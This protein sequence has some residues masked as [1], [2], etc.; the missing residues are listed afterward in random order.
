MCSVCG[1]YV[2]SAGCPENDGSGA[3]YV[4]D[5]CSS[6]IYS[7]EDYYSLDGRIYCED[8]IFEARRQAE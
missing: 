1:H 8:C 6:D 5:S 4:C 3:I 2:C 7:G